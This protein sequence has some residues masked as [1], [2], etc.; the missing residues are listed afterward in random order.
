[1]LEGYVGLFEDR[2]HSRSSFAAD[3]SRLHA[4]AVMTNTLDVKSAVQL[5]RD[6]L[7]AVGLDEKQLRLREPPAVT[8][9]DFPADASEQTIKLPLYDVFWYFPPDQQPKFGDRPAVGV[10][11]SAVTRRLAMFANNCPWTPKL[12]GLTNSFR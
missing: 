8:Q 9:V 4:A 2:A 11:V 3:E 5:A 1:M 7:H 12:S 10:Q 6:S